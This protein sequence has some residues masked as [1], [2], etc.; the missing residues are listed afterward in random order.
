M[1]A[2]LI[3]WWRNDRMRL[4]TD[5]LLAASQ[6]GELLLAELPVSSPEFDLVRC[7]ISELRSIYLGT[8]RLG[9]ELGVEDVETARAAVWRINAAFV[10]LRRLTTNTV[11]T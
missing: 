4:L 11:P 9:H 7:A 1:A 5:E 10:A 6:D 2:D 3:E 8:L